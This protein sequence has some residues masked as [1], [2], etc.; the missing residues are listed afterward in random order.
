MKKHIVS[1]MVIIFVASLAAFILT[2][3]GEFLSIV[4]ISS[5][6]LLVLLVKGVREIIKKIIYFFISTF[7]PSRPQKPEEGRRDGV[8]VFSLVLILV[9]AIA[10]A[11][12]KDS[13]AMF[14]YY[15]TLAASFFG[16]AVFFVVLTEEPEKRGW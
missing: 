15:L 6:F 8:L 14:L 5:A 4:I 9:S 7:F 16:F 1:I 12:L 11:L 13:S 2:E 3:D 10:G